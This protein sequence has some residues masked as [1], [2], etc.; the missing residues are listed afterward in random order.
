MHFRTILGL[1]G[2]CAA[3]APTP[4]F[5]ASGDEP[6][7]R[8]RTA[9]ER[10]LV[11]DTHLDTPVHFR[12][13]GWSIVDRHTVAEDQSQV[14]YPRMVEGGLDGG[15]WAI[16]T[17]QGPLT[18]QGYANARDFA[19][20]RGADIREM[21]IGHPRKF[22]IALRADD[23]AAIARSGRRIVYL[24]ME[25]S[26]PIGEDLSL[27]DT[28]YAMGVRMFG[29][30]HFRDNQLADSS[31]DRPKWG[32]L[33]PMGRSFIER[34]NRL[35][36]MIDG[37]HAS[38]AALEQMISLSKTP[39]VLSHSGL[40][41]INDHPRNID[42][43]LLRRLAASGGVIQLYAVDFYLTPAPKASL[44]ARDVLEDKYPLES[45]PANQASVRAR[46]E[47]EINETYSP[48]A[49][50]ELLM[51]QLQHAIQV[52][53]IDH[54]GL[55][56]DWDGGGGVPGYEDITAL[57]KVTAWLLRAGYSQADVEKIMSGNVLR[58]LRQAESYAAAHRGPGSPSGQ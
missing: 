8:D 14:D 30:V 54:V 16:F 45:L 48:H 38:D 18:P 22:G 37:S 17:G 23:A 26:Y 56:A 49:D 52:A 31:T 19:L 7:A 11:L 27:M 58:V 2:V 29:P 32:G 47:R 50:F 21:A 55:G 25:N 36:A 28:F 6:S 44:E 51:R 24:S 43:A 12:R 4:G 33:S 15:F 34:A 1:I 13:R 39:I 9:H 20:K 40:K 41:A 57:P 53:G 5:S 10:A 3:L 46:G 35:G 42:D